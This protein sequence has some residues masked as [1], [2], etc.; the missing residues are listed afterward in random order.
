MFLFRSFLLGGSALMVVSAF[1]PAF[2]QTTTGGQ[3]ANQQVA[4][5][6]SLEEIV[7]FGTGQTR[8]VQ[9][10]GKM[11]I[12]SVAPGTSPLQIIQKMPGVNFQ[13]A[14]PF[15]AYE[16]AVRISIRGFNQNQLGFTLDGVPLGDM[17]YGNNN[18]LHISRAV[19]SDNIG[20]IELAQGAGALDTASTSNLGGTLK[21]TTRAPAEDFG[22]LV[23][24]TG[25]TENTYRPFVRVDTGALGTEGPRMF[26]SYGY[27]HIDKWKGDG[28]QK[29]HHVNGKVVQPVGED[30]SV[31][32]YINYSDRREQDYQ[33]LSLDLINRLGYKHDN[34]FPNYALALQVA[35]AGQTGQPFPAPI[36]TLD[37]SYF[38][39]SGLRKDLL[40]Y[41]ATD[42]AVT[43][44][45]TFNGNAYWHS[46]KG[47]GSW[48]TPYAPSPNGS[49]VS[50]RTTEY[51]INRKGVTASITAEIE[52]NELNAGVWYEHNK[53]DQ[54]RRFYQMGLTTPERSVLD[55]QSD[56]FR[57][58]FEFDFDTKTTVFHVQDTLRLDGFS[59]FA[60]FK[61]IN[62][63]NTAV[64]L[65][66]TIR[67]TIKAKDSFLPQAGATVDIN[68]ENE[69]FV[70]YAENM[71][72]FSASATS[73]PFS[74]TQ[75]GFDFI[76]T[77]LRPE[78]SRTVE[79]G[80]RFNLENFGGVIALYDVKFKDRLLSVSQGPGIIGA[81]TALSNV[82]S[83]KS[84]GAEFGGTLALTEDFSLFGSMAYNK[85][86]YAD[87]TVDGQG[88]VTATDGKRLVDAPKIL[89]KGELAYDDDIYFGRVTVSH[90]GKRFYTYLNDQPVKSYTLVDLTAGYRFGP[91]AGFAQGWEIQGN[92]T[93]LFDKKYVS[94]I[95][96]NG[97]ANSDPTG[98]NQTLLAGAP[99][100]AFVTI[101]AQF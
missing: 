53:F 99:M 41:A 3:A 45:I 39:A 75:A 43:D 26:L 21:F 93:N 64:P 30:S 52:N 71:R 95:G 83:V 56:P 74:T 98:T 37:D 77:R 91:G 48:I 22:T 68:D 65:V 72:A 23:Q 81:P 5:S 89:A 84:R 14:D 6:A 17:S 15:G 86:E 28:T 55:Y 60:G 62:A 76:R 50:F 38:D 100:Q 1:A 29:Y 92:I 73:G 42:L 20:G 70:T 67:G 24:F 66:G 36:R 7:V 69:L 58:Q 27:S 11:D 80:W 88:R 35:R 54:A 51:D 61:S 25:G 13:A 85:A 44:T 2:S 8:Q 94:T 46:N 34:F 33:D 19:T 59:L 9:S 101:R 57:T 32:Y 40:T 47:Q 4:S 12:E 79:A 78:K 90:T 16:W 87:N 82:G 63:E 96:S 10:V 18:G 49:P 97:F 31:S